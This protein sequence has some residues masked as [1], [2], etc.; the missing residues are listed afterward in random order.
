MTEHDPEERGA[1]ILF[2][3]T[4]QPR[5]FADPLWRTWLRMKRNREHRAQLKGNT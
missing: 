3:S 4:F 2:R 1:K 5:W